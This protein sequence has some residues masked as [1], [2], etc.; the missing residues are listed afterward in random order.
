MAHSSGHA[1]GADLTGGLQAHD[2]PIMALA[3]DSTSAFVV[4]GASDSNVRVWDVAKGYCTHSFKGHRGVIS[5]ARFHPDP[6][7]WTLFTGSEN[8]EVRVWDLL[9]RSCTAVLSSHVSSVRALDV[10]A[11]GYHLLSAGRDQVLNLWSLRTHELVK[12]LPVFEVSACRPVLWPAGHRRRRLLQA[13]DT[14]VARSEHAPQTIEAAFFVPAD[15]FPVKR[16]KGAAVPPTSGRFLCV[17]AGDK[18]ACV[19]QRSMTTCEPAPH[20]A[21]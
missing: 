10:A 5:C 12:T 2:T 14:S 9:Q 19:R 20:L 18:G 11:D 8:G 21:A 15:L 3:F 16:K 13:C 7:R 1:N 17:T 6:D 4:T